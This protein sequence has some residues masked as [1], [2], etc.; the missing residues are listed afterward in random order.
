MKSFLHCPLVCVAAL[1]TYLVVHVFAAVFHHHEAESR[2]ARLLTSYHAR[3]HFQTAS[4]ADNDDE[5][6]CLLC[7]IFHLAQMP[8][9]A[10]HLEWV[11]ALHG[12]ALGAPA[13]L[14]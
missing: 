7:S 11:T 8:P 13:I 9:A 14:R 10:V 5:E 4:P 1:A 6:T 2:P 12:E 3:P